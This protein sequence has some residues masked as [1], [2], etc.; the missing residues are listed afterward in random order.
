MR[1]IQHIRKTLTGPWARQV[2]VLDDGL[3]DVGEQL[4]TAKKILARGPRRAWIMVMF[5][6]LCAAADS[7]HGGASNTFSAIEPLLRRRV[8]QVLT[9]HHTRSEVVFAIETLQWL[10]RRRDVPL[11]LQVRRDYADHLDIV[12]HCDGCL[13]GLM[14]DA[15]G[16]ED[17]ALIAFAV[18]ELHRSPQNAQS[19]RWAL[20]AHGSQGAQDALRSL[21][22]NHDP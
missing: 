14:T 19:W 15:A 18:A 10:V 11:I 4:V 3:R 22:L 5:H 20:E 17:P 2:E 21:D 6:Y 1:D 13:Q 9:R 7:R 16:R 12:K 8:L